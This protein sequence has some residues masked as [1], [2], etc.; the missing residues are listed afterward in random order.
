MDAF[1]FLFY[2]VADASQNPAPAKPD[3]SHF[4]K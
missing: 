2:F 1:E 3:D 4:T